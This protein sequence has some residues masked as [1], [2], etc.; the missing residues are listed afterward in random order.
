MPKQKSHRG[1][2][3]RVK[4]TKNGKIKRH[5]GF[6]GHLMSSKSPERRRRLRRAKLVAKADAKAI[7]S[8]LSV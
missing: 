3:K 2:R 8:R 4:V 1:L 6:A 7:I 5:S